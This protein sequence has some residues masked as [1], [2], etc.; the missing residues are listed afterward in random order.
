[1]FQD[2]G[3]L[4]A[5]VTRGAVTEC[6]HTAH[7]IV[8]SPD[9]VLHSI[10]NPELLNP[11]RSTAKPLIAE[12]SLPLLSSVLDDQTLAL[13]CS[14]H[15]GEAEHVT[16]LGEVLAQQGIDQEVLNLGNHAPIVPS[17]RYDPSPE[18]TLLHPLQNNCSG[19]HIGLIL[20]AKALGQNPSTYA[21]PTG[22]ALH[23]IDNHIRSLAKRVGSPVSSSADGCGIPTFAIKLSALA[24]L[25]ARFYSH[26]TS[27]ELATIRRALF[28]NPE[29]VGGSRRATTAI[30]RHGV[31]AKD[32]F[33][34]LFALAFLSQERIPCGIAIKVDSGSDAIAQALA[35][36]VTE[37][38]TGR[39]L[40]VTD[41]YP[42]LHVVNQLGQP[43]GEIR[44]RRHVLHKL[45]EPIAS[46]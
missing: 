30:L 16:R 29:L 23:H 10:G 26:P 3:E 7:V 31:L 40:D 25:Y 32:G 34:G 22:K 12:S 27:L 35:I 24:T 36:V 2:I 14:S 20:L 13:L 41:L 39:T 1:M 46:S 9:R 18:T 8:C 19:K 4:L 11:L 33:D 44:V 45:L 43:T 21:D 15:N 6:R 5:E 28:S 38:L 17:L 42:G 37:I